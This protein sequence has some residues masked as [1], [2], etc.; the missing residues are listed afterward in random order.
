MFGRWE[1]LSALVVRGSMADAGRVF[2]HERAHQ[3]L[4]LSECRR[5]LDTER[6]GRIALSVAALPSVVPVFYRVVDD[7]I[8]LGVEDQSLFAALSDNIVA[9]EVD[10]VDQETKVGWTVLVVGRSRPAPDL[11]LSVFAIPGIESSQDGLVG[12]P[13]RLIGI[14]IDR[15]SGQRTI[16][17]SAPDPT[18]PGPEVSVSEASA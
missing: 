17:P 12:P 10:H 11:S 1:G 7:R 2:T 15:L 9:F 6:L 5:L 13:D 4:N 14:S 16:E 18:G 3:N 8:V